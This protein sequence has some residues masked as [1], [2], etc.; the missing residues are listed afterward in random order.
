M[1]S[2][3]KKETTAQQHDYITDEGRLNY[4]INLATEL[5]IKQME[6]G[7]ATSQTISYFLKRGSEE[8]AFKLRQMELEL[9][10][11]KAKTEQIRMQQV[12]AELT[13]QAI[14]AMTDYQPS[15][16]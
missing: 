3:A 6:D 12:S 8:E 11:T 1:K 13:E 2:L 5:A 15:R 14:K 16:E 10:L 9:E 7:T 4:A